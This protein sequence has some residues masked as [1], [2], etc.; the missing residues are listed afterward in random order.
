LLPPFA[1]LFVT[2]MTDIALWGV[3][4]LAAVFLGVVTGLVL[5]RIFK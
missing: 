5:F 4:F 3:L 1:V 2:A